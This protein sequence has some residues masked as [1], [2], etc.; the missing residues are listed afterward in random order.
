MHHGYPNVPQPSSQPGPPPKKGMST[1]VIGAITFAA[2]VL[3][4]SCIIGIG[5]FVGTSGDAL[6]IEA[7]LLPA[8]RVEEARAEAARVEAARVESVRL[9]AARVEAARVTREGVAIPAHGG[10]A[11]FFMD[12]T[13]VTVAEYDQC[14]FAGK[15][16]PPKERK[17]VLLNEG[18]SG[19]DNHPINAV[20]WD[21]ANEYCASVGKR[22]PTETEWQYAAQ[23]ADGRKYPWGN[24]EPSDQLCWSGAGNTAG[25]E[26]HPTC[27]VSS[28]PK[29]DSPFGLSDMAGNVEEFTSTP[30]GSAH[31]IRGGHFWM[32]SFDDDISSLRLTKPERSGA[33]S[34][35]SDYS[36]FT[37][38]RCA[39]SVTMPPK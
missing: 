8:A 17:A 28:F 16:T 27:A 22:L 29:G 19:R 20:T 7:P 33:C 24:A 30:N 32:K 15:C 14:V 13:E 5:L 23:G 2:I 9:E 6:H 31:V 12:K 26:G 38:F 3:G 37:G 25:A 1:L 36:P 18:T 39:R 35:P 34:K 10:I 21:Q 11:A 4:G